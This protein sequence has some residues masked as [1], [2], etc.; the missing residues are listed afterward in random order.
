MEIKT[1]GPI[2]ERAFA[3]LVRCAEAGDAP[4]A[5]LCADHHVGYAQPIGGAIAY[6][7]YVSP[8]GVGYDIGCL[9]AGTLVTMA[10][11]RKLP[12]ESIALRGNLLGNANGVLTDVGVTPIAI[13]K[14]APVTL[15]LSLINGDKLRLT[16]DHQLLTPHDW[17]EAERLAQ[18]DMISVA[19]FVGIDEGSDAT[20]EYDHR[21]IRLF[22][23]AVGDG[24]VTTSKNRVAFYTSRDE[25]AL[26]LLTDLRGLGHTNANMH[27]RIRA[28]GSI[29]NQ[30][31]CN[32]AQ[33]HKLFTSWGLVP[34]R[35]KWSR[36]A[37]Q[38]LLE[39]P[40]YLKVAWLGGLFSAEMAAPLVRR[41]ILLGS[42]L[43]KQGGLNPLPLLTIVR[44]MLASLK[45][46]SEIYLSGQPKDG[47]QTYQL[48]VLG[49]QK[50]AIQT[51]RMIGFPYARYKQAKAAEA[52]SIVW[53]RE[54][55]L[56]KRQ[57]AN[58]LCRELRQQGIKVHELAGTV[59]QRTGATYTHSMAMKA[60]YHQRATRSA[61]NITL[62][63]CVDNDFVWVAIE[64]IATEHE[65]ID[66]YDIPLTHEAHNFI[67]NGIVAHNCG[68]KAV[69]TNL[70]ASEINTA[71]V[72]NEV[73]RRVSFGVGRANNEPVDHPVLEEIATAEFAPQRKLVS[74]AAQQLGTVGSG[75][76][77]VDLFEDEEGRLWVG[78]HFGSRGFGHRTASGFLAMAKGADF[79]DRVNEG[80]MDSPPTLLATD[81]YL[82]DAYIEAMTLA[83]QYAYAGRDLVVDKVLEILDAEALL[84]VHNHHNFAWREKH[85][86]EELWV[87][88]KGCT[89]AFP[90][91]QGF[92][93][94][95]MGDI[96][97]VLE[98][99]ASPDAELALFSTV[100]GAGR[101]MSRTQAAGKRKWVK[102]ANGAR[103]QTTVRPGLVDW[104]KVRRQI[105]AQGVEL[106]G[107][108]PDE[109]PEVYKR[110]D[111]VLQYHEGTIAI[112]HRLRPIGVAM[113]GAD[114]YD[115]YKD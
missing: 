43:M 56:H 27:R 70:Q 82:G 19:S 77:Y 79:E 15:V 68:N 83:G 23:Y 99:V 22:G 115:P 26:A 45:I 105:R 95:T 94:A 1:F 58:A 31:Y 46:D 7:D 78:V 34:G 53:Q 8:S 40:D 93:G 2:D 110:L 3:Q 74:L 14:K 96:S 32:S 76:H 91:Q 18:G 84:E 42:A 75:N 50:A 108:G 104:D 81:T 89:P 33:L 57:H 113:A 86:G 67:A 73:V 59:Q 88:R 10:D 107:S 47:K 48:M 112:R 85:F 109:A 37:L 9:A 65:E 92:V 69:L 64:S 20:S 5:V 114:V 62:M 13:A 49:G 103:V 66:V 41:S 39:L 61:A 71:A 30:V 24:H 106:R 87:V 35:S 52:M 12:I 72:M 97:V 90:G 44:E 54:H 21:L 55:L 80:E 28:N 16:P 51:W 4:N 111:E 60:I 98:G 101:V 36:E 11:G 38:W 102:G 17:V 29:E 25:D 6:R 100:H 63:P